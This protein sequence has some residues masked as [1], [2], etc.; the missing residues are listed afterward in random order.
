LGERITIKKLRIQLT[1]I[2]A[3]VIADFTPGDSNNL[4]WQV[5]GLP[6]VFYSLCVYLLD[7]PFVI[8]FTQVHF[9]SW[10]LLLI[11]LLP[12]LLLLIFSN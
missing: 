8:C 7:G 4:W 9:H 3:G 11:G 10:F 5:W 1:W 6:L 2:I 12:L